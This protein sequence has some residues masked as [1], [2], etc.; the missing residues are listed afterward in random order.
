MKVILSFCVLITLCLNNLVSAN[1]AQTHL[2][3]FVHQ[4]T[5][6][7]DSIKTRVNQWVS[8][9]QITLPIAGGYIDLQSAIM[10]VEQTG[11]VNQSIWGALDTQINGQWSLGH[12]ALIS[13][14]ASLPTGKSLDKNGV[15]L[16]QV[17]LRN[18]LNFPVKTFGQGLNAGGALSVV[19]HQGHWSLSMGGG[20]AY[21]GKYNPVDSVAN[22]KP[23]DEISGSLGFDYTYKKWVYRVTTTGT[24]YLTD[25]H[26]GLV[27]F[28][29][30][31]QLLL[32]GSMLY[33]GRRFRLKAEVTEIIRMKNKDLL[34]NDQFLYELRDSNG[35]DFRAHIETSWTPTSF[36][37]FFGTGYFKHL[38]ANAHVPTSPIYQG[39]A[40]L[41]EGGGGLALSFGKAVHLTLHG[42]R[43]TGKAEDATLILSAFNLRG[44]LSIVF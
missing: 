36:V 6:Q 41:F 4:M 22:Y 19:H 12:R 9:V 29:N 3:S 5:L 38:T 18:D 35:N 42:T 28:R 17:L 27:V 14:H 40:H 30:G 44:A 8:P 23:G 25:R 31:K 2:S 34:S 20:Y 37:T 33:T 15:G 43:L 13:L 10:G 26:N 1:P 16:L 11:L 32:Q 7:R 24:F 21:K 39:N